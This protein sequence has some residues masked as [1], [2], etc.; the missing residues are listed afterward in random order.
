[1]NWITSNKQIICVQKKVS[2]RTHSFTHKITAYL[3]DKQLSPHFISMIGLKTA[4]IEPLCSRAQWMLHKEVLHMTGITTVGGLSL[5]TQDSGKQQ[6]K[7][8]VQVRWEE[9][10][11]P[12]LRASHIRRQRVS[13]KSV[14]SALI[15]SQWGTMSSFSCHDT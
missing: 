9:P 12:H 4:Y 3:P 14:A 1:M 15:L 13:H 6:S 10:H 5:T 8:Q 2:H 11:H 7:S